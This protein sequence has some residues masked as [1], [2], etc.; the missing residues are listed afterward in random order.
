M[1]MTLTQEV[2][3]TCLYMHTRKSDGRIFYIGIGDK[4]RPYEKSGRNVH[5]RNTVKTHDY[6][7][8]ILADC[9]TW[10]RACE[11]EI[12]MI[13]FYGRRDKV[14]GTLVNKTCWWIS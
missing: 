12:L 13:A 9:L 14:G 3:D 7:V 6:D 2:R 5:W 4:D 11:L 10:A 1:E 8:T